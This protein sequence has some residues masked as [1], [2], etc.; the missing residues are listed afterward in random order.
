MDQIQ[1]ELDFEGGR[2]AP[3]AASCQVVQFSDFSRVRQARQLQRLELE[4]AQLVAEIV[5]SVEH[6]TGRSPDAEA[7]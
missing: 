2:E 5:K 4:K 1:L 6:I 3:S 7:M